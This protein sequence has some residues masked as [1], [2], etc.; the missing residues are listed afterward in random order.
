MKKKRT[1]TFSS[2][3]KDRVL[4]GC[5]KTNYFVALL[6]NVDMMAVSYV[7]SSE[8]GQATA[9]AEAYTNKYLKFRKTLYQKA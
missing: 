7:V 9:L 8:D 3:L 5:R 1:C 2:T 4:E 6:E